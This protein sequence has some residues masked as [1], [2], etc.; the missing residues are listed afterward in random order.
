MEK[1]QIIAIWL[2]GKCEIAPVTE[3]E[4]MP[5]EGFVEIGISK[6][7]QTTLEA[8]EGESFELKGSGGSTVDIIETEGGLPVENRGDKAH[9]ALQDTR[10]DRGRV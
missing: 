9:H 8:T 5:S 6:Q 3:D 10:P 1:S 2:G 4:S 7:K